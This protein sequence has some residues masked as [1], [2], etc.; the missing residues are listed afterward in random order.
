MN[1]DLERLIQLQAADQQIARLNAEIAALPKRVAAIESKLAD[2]KAQVEKSK[3]AIAATQT[4]RRRLEGEIKA[5]QDKISKYRDQSLSVKTNEQYKALLQEIQFAEA[6]IRACEDKIL[7]GMITTE[8]QEK[9]LKAAEAEL[10]SE[11]AEI[12]KEKA[13][14]RSRTAEDEAQLKEWAGKR[15]ALRASVSPDALRYYDRVLKFRGTAI[16]EAR[17]QICVTCNV[18]LRPQTYNDV[19]TNEQIIQCDSCGR[20][21]YYDPSHEP[22][23]A[24]AQQRQR[25]EETPAES[26]AAQ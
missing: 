22:E 9:D 12:E 2:T 4:E 23:P 14:A 19:K 17:D 8:S 5:Q 13:E 24:A 18:M 25:A 26:S 6:E 1:P 7:E 10:K 16:S 21:L 3:Q 15:D 11:A 20:I